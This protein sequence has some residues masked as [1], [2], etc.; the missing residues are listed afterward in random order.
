MTF[1]DRFNTT[2]RSN[3]SLINVVTYEEARFLSMVA[4]SPLFKEITFRSLKEISCS[5]KAC[6]TASG[7]YVKKIF[8]IQSL[9]LSHSE[10]IC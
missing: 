1:L 8:F 3:H 7:R 9:G 6:S 5:V 2:I 10:T 4:E